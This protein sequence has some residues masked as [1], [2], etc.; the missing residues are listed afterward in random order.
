MKEKGANL[1]SS[2]FDIQ[3]RDTLCIQLAPGRNLRYSGLWET[4]QHDSVL[5]KYAEEAKAA[6]DVIEIILK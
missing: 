3:I 4:D 6:G 2:K 1:L 5:L